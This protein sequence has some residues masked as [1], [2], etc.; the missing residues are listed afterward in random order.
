MPLYNFMYV[1]QTQPE[2]TYKIYRRYLVGLLIQGFHIN[3]LSQ[4][5]VK[6]MVHS[7]GKFCHPQYN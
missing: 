4:K 7:D 1:K 2:Q 6:S 3:K 5:I